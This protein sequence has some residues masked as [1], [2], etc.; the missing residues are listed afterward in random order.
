MKGVGLMKVQAKSTGLARLVAVVLLIVVLIA[1]MMPTMALANE[2]SS[3]YVTYSSTQTTEEFCFQVKV[4]AGATFIIPNHGQELGSNPSQKYDWHIEWGDG[5]S[6]NSS[7]V[8]R[9]PSDGIPHT[10]ANAGI[11]DIRISPNG[12]T[13]MWMK[14]FGFDSDG[15]GANAPTN[16][17]MV[18]AIISPF[19]PN[20]T[21][22]FSRM[23]YNCK[24]LTSTGPGFSGPEWDNVS[25]ITY[26]ASGL[27]QGCSSDAFTMHPQF[28]LPKNV[29]KVGPY[30]FDRMFSGCSGASF[31]MNDVLNLPQGLT[32]I[33][34]SFCRNM[35]NECSG[36]S[37]NMNKIFNL[38]P[39]ITGWSSNYMTNRGGFAQGMFS[40]CSGASFTM[41]DIFNLPQGLTT[42]EFQFAASMFSDC[43]G[44]SFNMNKVFNLPQG[45][46]TIGQKNRYSFASC[47]FFKC[48]GDAFTMNDIFN[49]P[50]NM[51]DCGNN[52]CYGMFCGCWGKS[53]TMN[54]VFNLPQAITMAENDFATG[55]FDSCKG[56]AFTMNDIFN[57]PQGITRVGNNFAH[58]MFWECSGL[59]FQVNDVFK[60]PQ[61]SQLELDRSGVLSRV[62]WGVAAMQKR[63]AASIIN[64]PDASSV[65]GN[66][67]PVDDR[68]TFTSSFKAFRDRPV[69]EANWGG[70]ELIGLTLD[71]NGG[72]FPGGN[73]APISE[74]IWD[75]LV[76]QGIGLPA[77]GD[78]NAPV[79]DGKEFGGWANSANPT[80]PGYQLVTSSFETD[81]AGNAINSPVN[82]ELFAVW[83]DPSPV[84]PPAGGGSNSGGDQGGNGGSTG[85]GSTGGSGSDQSGS[86]STGG[87]SGSGGDQ[88]GNGGSTG[89]GSN[90]GGNQSGNGGSTGGG[91]TGG[92]TD[93]GSGSDQGGS[94]G[95]AGGGSN[96]GSDQSGSGG[97][98]GGGN[99]GDSSTGGSD[100]SG[101]GG[102]GGSGSTVTPD[103]ADN[104]SGNDSGTGSGTDTGAGTDTG[105]A[106]GNGGSGDT[107]TV[108]GSNAGG[109]GGADNGSSNGDS[110]GSEAGSDNNGP[111][112]NSSDNTQTGSG[113]TSGNTG[114]NT[115]TGTG[116]GSGNTGGNNGSE[117]G[118]GS[119]GNNSPANN[120][121]SSDNGSTGSTGNTNS[122]SA[123]ESHTTHGPDI[124]SDDMVPI[125]HV[126]TQNLP[127]ANTSKDIKASNAGRTSY[128]DTPK[129]IALPPTGDTGARSIAN[130]SAAGVPFGG[131][132]ITGAWSLLSLLLCLISAIVAIATL[133]SAIAKS[134]KRRR[135]NARQV[136]SSRETLQKYLRDNDAN[137]NKEAKNRRS[138]RFWVAPLACVLMALITIL[139]WLIL[140]NLMLP[141]VWINTHT[142]IIL[143]LTIICLIL[144]ATNFAL[145]FLRQRQE[146]N[147]TIIPT[148][149][150][151]QPLSAKR[152]GDIK[153]R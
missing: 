50:P 90:S 59:G 118:N 71:A 68:E 91:S 57:L 132:S 139:V 150:V 15:A 120:N 101:S 93:S 147:P 143:V 51:T 125:S 84:T 108:S 85:G 97:A 37:F 100:S 134:E 87:G 48:S 49:I 62:F 119:N 23:F 136:A 53:F 98:A 25:D 55:M 74:L 105:S 114:G 138:S 56:D 86:G 7:G 89:G 30:T 36:A 17:A 73:P 69:L 20:M 80:D 3:R 41:N 131:L 1:A 102:S 28:N 135:D 122:G 54:K 42:P 123:R 19:T 94:G 63:T 107:G 140:D 65:F 2:N 14:N 67:T 141:M 129:V 95:A 148:I 149:T 75:S 109:G 112:A 22:T 113:N 47:M 70:V 61:L 43:S 128:P 16:K 117:S 124:L 153:A 121:G 103:V 66:L 4:P 44:A 76:S 96:S 13:S 83:N 6:E 126:G 38:P 116:S 39:G 45:M 133:A 11:Y 31:T 18:H 99:S 81:E 21:S 92:S 79:L 27:F 110:T 82:I 137:G 32:A 34:N 72:S 33:D 111:G 26:F 104:G 12:S 145:K 52:F 127:A 35:F 8:S 151:C 24:E 5:S 106:N 10:Y 130:I 60:F 9:N 152:S 115:G 46:T 144:S 40:G 142:P 88:S 78:A 64:N 29:K 77:P 146:N 58:D